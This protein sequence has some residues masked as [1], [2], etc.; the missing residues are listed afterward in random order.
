MTKMRNINEL[1]NERAKMYN[2]KVF[3]ISPEEG[4]LTY[5]DLDINVKG[6]MK[7]LINLNIKKG[8]NIAIFMHNGID[9]VKSFLGIISI[10]AIVIPINIRLREMDIKFLLKDSETKIVIADLSINEEMERVAKYLNIKIINK[11]EI[12]K[13]ELD[14]EEDFNILK[15]DVAVILYTSGTTGDP[16]GVMLTHNNLITSAKNVIVGHELTENDVSLCVLPLYHISAE[17]LSLITPLCSGGSVIMPNKFSAT[18]FWEIASKYKATWV[19]VVPTILAILLAKGLYEKNLDLSNL[20]FGR[21]A[22]GPLSIDLN[23]RFEEIFKIPILETYGLTES[24]SQV[25]TNPR[26][27]SKRKYGSVGIPVGC[28]LKI[29]DEN[30]KE[31]KPFQ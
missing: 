11:D 24:T 15:D 13:N 23:K 1:I 29:I 28:K 12:I 27:L 3:L 17:V 9:F 7:F 21:S 31:V 30:G 22:S 8:D 20:K 4:T 16:K 14:I 10:G 26:D 25:V 19:Q 6:V 2:E 5:R 18:N